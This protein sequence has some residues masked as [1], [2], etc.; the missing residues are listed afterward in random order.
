MLIGFDRA[1]SP[2]AAGSE[3]SGKLQRFFPSGSPSRLSAHSHPRGLGPD[4]RRFAGLDS[5]CANLCSAAI[6]M[7]L[8]N[9]MIP[10]AFD[11]GENLRVSSPSWDSQRVSGFFC[12]N[13]RLQAK[14]VSTSSATID[15]GA[16][17]GIERQQSVSIGLGSRSVS[18]LDSYC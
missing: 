15:V 6:P 17:R 3:S 1:K 5:R 14:L 7:M 9:T 4:E 18:R 11:H 2:E 16:Q 12:L 13:G 10:E 8:A